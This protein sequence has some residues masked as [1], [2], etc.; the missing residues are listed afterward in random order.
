MI[1]K[2][3][4][5]ASLFSII[6]YYARIKVHFHSL[7]STFLT[8]KVQLYSPLSTFFI[9]ECP[10][11]LTNVHF[12][13][14]RMSSITHQCPLFSSENVQFHSQMSTFLFT[15]VQFYILIK[16]LDTKISS[17]FEFVYFSHFVNSINLDLF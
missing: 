6:I 14:L 17:C 13:H 16:K 7:L 15:N 9:Y 11:L 2:S 1:K 4:L 12:F 8:M 10:V 3:I 5:G